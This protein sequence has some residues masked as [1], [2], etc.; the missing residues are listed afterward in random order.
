LGGICQ[1][2]KK[3]NHRYDAIKK[4][5]GRTKLRATTRGEEGERGGKNKLH[6]LTEISGFGGVS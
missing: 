6:H 1:N 3:R 2:G 4:M 5:F